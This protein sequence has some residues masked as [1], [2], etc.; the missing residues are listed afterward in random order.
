MGGLHPTI[1]CP[2]AR[3]FLL[4]Q[5]FQD[6]DG[7]DKIVELINNVIVSLSQ[8]NT[9]QRPS[10]AATNRKFAKFIRELIESA[11]EYNE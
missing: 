10:A 3:V 1:T 7:Q 8:V 9:A 2:S 6:I 5:F 4:C 11:D